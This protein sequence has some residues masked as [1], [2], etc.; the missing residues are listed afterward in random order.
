MKIIGGSLKGRNF[1]MPAGI[2]PTQGVLRAAIFDILGHDLEG[3]SMLE[4]YAGSGAITFEAISRGLTNGV[5]VEHDPKHVAVIRENCELLNITLGAH[6]HLLEDDAMAA[7]KNLARSGQ[8]FDIV[9]FDPP[10]GLKLGKK[11][12]N[13]A[14]TRDILTGQN[15]VIAQVDKGDYLTV[16]D[17]FKVLVDRFYG[18]SH[19]LIIQKVAENQVNKE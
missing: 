10:F 5:M 11:T 8:R 9:F 15:L 3:F 7:L 12:L 17:G 6:Y 14:T 18:S 2:R 1:Y 4:L 13:L 19:L 16:P